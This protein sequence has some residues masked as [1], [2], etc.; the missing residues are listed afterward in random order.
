M[1]CI[2]VILGKGA[3]F[4]MSAR[5]GLL[6]FIGLN[7]WS[8]G[9]AAKAQATCSDREWTRLDLGSGNYFKRLSSQ[10]WEMQGYMQHTWQPCWAEDFFTKVQPPTAYKVF[11]DV[12]RGLHDVMEWSWAQENRT[13]RTTSNI[14][15]V[16]QIREAP[17]VNRWLKVIHEDG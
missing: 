8:L 2:P 11:I 13:D 9:T 1:P 12:A 6:C 7:G 3:C 5:Y 4:G 16:H 17:V 10:T 15:S 14:T